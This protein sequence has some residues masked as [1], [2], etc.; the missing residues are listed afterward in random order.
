[1][2]KQYKQ[3]TMIAFFITLF[4]LILSCVTGNFFS[5]L[6]GVIGGFFAN[7][8]IALLD[9]CRDIKKKGGF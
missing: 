9:Q 7:G 5:M 3:Y 8:T 6:F 4:F 2:L 1:M